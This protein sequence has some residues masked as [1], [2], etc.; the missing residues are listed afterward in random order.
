MDN[1]DYELTLFEIFIIAAA[2][3][4]LYNCDVVPGGINKQINLYQKALEVV[5]Y[6]GYNRLSEPF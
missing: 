3:Q 5:Y 4:F 1:E 2:K 6:N